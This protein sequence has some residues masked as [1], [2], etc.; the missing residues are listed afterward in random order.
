MANFTKH[1][2]NQNSN[3]GF[4]PKSVLNKF[5]E[6]WQGELKYEYNENGFYSLLPE[7]KVATI[8]IEN[9]IVEDIEKIE[10]K[11]GKKNLTMNDLIN[12]SYNSQKELVLQEKSGFK[13][14]INGFNVKKGDLV[15]SRAGRKDI[16]NSKIILSP[17]KMNNEMKMKIGNG[18]KDMELTFVQ[19]PFE[20]LTSRKFVTLPSSL[21]NID[22]IFNIIDNEK[23]G[24]MK[25]HININEKQIHDAKTYVE[26][27]EFMQGI[28]N[29]GMYVYGEKLKVKEKE[30]N[31]TI[32][33]TNLIDIWKKVIEIEKCL[34]I[35][36]NIDDFDLD[37]ETTK[38]ILDLFQ[39]LV[40]KK[41]VVLLEKINSIQ[42]EYEGD[43]DNILEII[44]AS[45][46]KQS[47]YFEIPD[48]YKIT[49]F[50]KE[51]KLFCLYG[52][53]NIRFNCIE[54]EDEHSITV[55]IDENKYNVKKCIMFFKT[56]EELKYFQKDENHVNVMAE[57]LKLEL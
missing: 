37:R 19:Q 49:L 41:P 45:D 29:Q 27:L 23:N 51:V 7:N 5:N 57:D 20:S 26:T 16:L 21:L 10:E 48:E 22:F 11:C 12:Y 3:K 32:D 44:K 25:F 42:F 28:F 55:L 33:R 8:S 43:N 56:N 1:F 18:D 4:L 15:I 24:S 17:Q 53:F 50:K 54:S 35:K 46:E 52:Y 38:S 31:Q 40:L 2:K 47:F 30:P 6:Q 9:F 39:G 36:F 34:D 14:N 13:F